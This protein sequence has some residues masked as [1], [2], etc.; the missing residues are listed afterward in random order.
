MGKP[1]YNYGKTANLKA[2]QQ[3]QMD[4][5]LKR[6]AAKQSKANIKSSNPDKESDPAESSLGADITEGTA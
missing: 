3:K 5:D 1:M 6:R 4:R 2:Q